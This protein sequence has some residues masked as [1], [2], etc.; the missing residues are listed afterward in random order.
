MK[1]SCFFLIIIAFFSCDS[2]NT[3]PKYEGGYIYCKKEYADHKLTYTELC[4]YEN[5][6]LA[7]TESYHGKLLNGPVKRYHENGLLGE[8]RFF[9]MGVPVKTWKL[10]SEDGNLIRNAYFSNGELIYAK[11]YDSLGNV[12]RSLL[13]I[14]VKKL[15]RLDTSVDGE[16][17]DSLQIE[18]EFTELDS[19]GVIALIDLNDDQ[20]YEDTLFSMSK[21]IIYGIDT[22]LLQEPKKVSG[23]LIEVDLLKKEET[24]GY[25]FFYEFDPP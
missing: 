1:D 5:G 14:G 19:A 11:D 16:L 23:T 7:S 13:P 4:Y 9:E 18:L 17:I 6:K 20:V 8:E 15:E 24:G 21:S 3:P 10:L 12:V 2:G 22:R 25:S